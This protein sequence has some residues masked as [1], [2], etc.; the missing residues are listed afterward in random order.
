[1]TTLPDLI[2]KEITVEVTA[3]DIAIGQPSL[4]RKC[5]FA[6]AFNRT[7]RALG[8]PATY[9]VKVYV[10]YSSLLNDKVL[11]DALDLALPQ[12]ARD[13]ITSVDKHETVKPTTF[14]FKLESYE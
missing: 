5:P 7:L 9:V 13:F 14:T 3:E 8:L 1:M 4:P 6:L 2:G 11:G 10:W 12:E